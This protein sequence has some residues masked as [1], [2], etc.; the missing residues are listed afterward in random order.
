M[1]QLQMPPII[2]AGEATQEGIQGLGNAMALR[3][4]LDTQKLQQNRMMMANQEMQRGLQKRAELE[5]LLRTSPNPERDG[6]EWA[7]R[8][9]PD[10]AGKIGAQYLNRFI[11]KVTFDPKGAAAELENS[12]GEKVEMG[13]RFSKLHFDGG[14]DK[15]I[16]NA[17][18]QEFVVNDALA[19]A[20]VRADMDRNEARIETDPESGQ[21]Y[22]WN[23][24]T[25]KYDIPFG[26]PAAAKPTNLS[27]TE[28][29]ADLMAQAH[30][31]ATGQDA[32]PE[33]RAKWMKEYRIQPEVE[34]EPKKYGSMQFVQIY[35]KDGLPQH[36]WVDT[37]KQTITPAIAGGRTEPRD[38]AQG[39]QA[40][41]QGV[42]I[43]LPVLDELES[44]L[45][46]LKTG[47]VWGRIA[48][49]KLN[50][51]GGAGLGA[52]E[53]AIRSKL[54]RLTA[55][56]IF[57]EGGKQLT[58]TEKAMIEPYVV[59]QNDTLTTALAKIPEL[60]KRS[61]RI[62]QARFSMMNPRTRALHGD[63]E[64]AQPPAATGGETKIINGVPYRKVQ[65]GWQKAQQ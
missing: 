31:Q 49:F 58:G 25:K 8:N 35:D 55:D 19:V 48:A 39:S 65:G 32:T 14:L 11:Q 42:E 10:L 43:T 52:Q 60:R 40:V 59:N 5:A 36:Y 54:G 26:G 3:S 64:G 51:L 20:Q 33:Q 44:E 29:Y 1:A 7:K 16:D 27:D 46:A 18:G 21:K 38:I 6:Y 22:Q 61:L 57:G 12:T 41:L 24:K 15:Y 47:P 30:K 50:Q 9:D 56:Q 45:S 23:T 37:V 4:N 63:M 2:R 28:A 17:T 62:K 13:K 53:S 34:R